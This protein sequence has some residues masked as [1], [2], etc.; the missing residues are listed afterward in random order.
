MEDKKLKQYTNLSMVVFF[1][2]IIIGC[3]VALTLF[4]VL[5]V[6]TYIDINIYLFDVIVLVSGYFVSVS[7]YYIGKYIFGLISGYRLVNFNFW[8]INFIKDKNNKMKIKLCKLYNLGCR[9]MMAPNVKNPNYKLY[10]LG[11]TIFSMPY[12]IASLAL[13]YFL[14][15]ENDLRYYLLFISIFIPFVCVG[16]LIPVRMDGNNEGFTLRL[17][18]KEGQVELFHRNLLQHE[19][20]VN[21][22]SELKYFECR[23]PITPFDLDTLYY[24]YYYCIDN[25]EFLKALRISEELI[26]N[27]DAITDLNKI[28]LGYTG[29]I[30]ELCRQKRFDESD[31]YFWE[32]KHDIRNVVRNKNNFES[33]KICL[34]VAAY[35]ETNYDEY[36]N[37]YYKKEK[38]SKRYEFISRIDKEVDII[39]QTIQL[40][41]QDHSD[42]YV[43]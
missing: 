42:W 26:K 1:L 5:Y 18:K 40:I 22:K 4:Q 30:Y 23:N 9:V 36:L 32:L 20:L 13:F 3:I 21:G 15:V 31:R 34:F 6:Q 38:A 19:A 27:S 39:N 12:F 17:M 14:N 29:K 25:Q 35:M 11:G 41:Q 8:I 37:L 43:E 7:L 16:N 33:I 24:N 10:L 28:Y 2:L